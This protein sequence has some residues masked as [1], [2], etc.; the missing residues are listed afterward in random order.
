MAIE[1]NKRRVLILGDMLELGDESPAYHEQIGRH[2]AQYDFD[3]A[4][5]VGP[6]SAHILEGA[7]AAGV[8][9][10]RVQHFDTA[11]QCAAR[12]EGIL[13]EDDLVYLKGSRG[14]GLEAVLKHYNGPEEEN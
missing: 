5:L 2:L 12:I 9:R 3:L 6:M 8:A 11:E 13:R 10:G 7:T 4:L 1:T 14:I